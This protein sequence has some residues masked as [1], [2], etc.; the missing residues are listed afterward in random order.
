[1]DGIKRKITISLTDHTFVITGIKTQDGG[2]APKTVDAIRFLFSTNWL[3]RHTVQFFHKDSDS[4]DASAARWHLWKLVE[5]VES[6][7]NPGFSPDEDTV[8][9]QYKFWKASWSKLSDTKTV[10]DDGTTEVHQICSS[11]NSVEVRPDV[12]I[13]LN[14][15]AGQTS[16]H[17]I[18]QDPNAIKWSLSVSNYPYNTTNSRL[19]LKF[20]FSSRM[21]VKDFDATDDKD[22][23]KDPNEGAVVVGDDGS[24]NKPLASYT[25]NINVTGNGCSATGSVL[26]TIIREGE[27]SNDTDVDLPSQ[28]SDEPDHSISFD[29]VR[30]VGYF[31]FITDCQPA[32]IL[33]DPQLGVGQSDAAT[34]AGIAVLPSVVFAVIALISLLL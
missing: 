27:W 34:S 30:R 32:T 23:S 28:P 11:I 3:P 24:G 18:S 13:C 26:R 12:T 29:A 5:Y 8:V 1:V 7:A 33:W 4:A 31:S 19:A 14:I 2:K 6:N 21:K 10:G 22:F 17:G 25:T 15:A 9:S 20:S 16:F